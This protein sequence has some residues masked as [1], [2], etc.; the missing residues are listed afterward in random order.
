MR[1]LGWDIGG[2][3][4][5]VAR[6][7]AAGHIEGVQQAGC[8]L[9]LGLDRL[10]TAMAQ[11]RDVLP[12][13]PE[14]RHIITMTGELTDYF[15][16]RREGVE[17]ILEHFKPSPSPFN[18]RVFAGE[19]GFLD[20]ANLASDDWEW[21][22]SANWMAS[23][24]WAARCLD[25]GI[26][27][28]VGSTT[29][30]FVVFSEGRPLPR[31]YTDHERMIH[32]ELVYSGIVRTPIMALATRAPVLG[33]WTPPMAEYFATTSDLYR[34]TGELREETDQHP[35]ADQGPKTLDASKRRL[36]RQFGVDA[37]ALPEGAM[38]QVAHFL[39]AQHLGRLRDALSLQVSRGLVS[40]DAPL[41]GAGI[42]RFLI[43]ELAE[44][45]Q[46]PFLDFKDLFEWEPDHSTF[47]AADCGPAA[48][49]AALS[50]A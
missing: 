48:A 41:V 15:A 17:A 34:I 14:D 4:L 1:I 25:E 33:T 32:D 3:H 44:E 30:D 12:W 47:D 29:S 22:A 8:P 43:Q 37:D 16:H 38:E 13:G 46:R 6:F 36:G 28:D 24:Q 39:R 7:N 35:A 11:L 26:F 45:C 20:P 19:R 27:I 10:E 49:V 21:I 5:K 9:W 40:R 18:C 50:F 42:G 31:G 23:A 2:A